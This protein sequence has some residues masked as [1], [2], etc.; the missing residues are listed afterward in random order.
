MHTSKR[1]IRE[2]IRNGTLDR[3][4]GQAML[5]AMDGTSEETPTTEEIPVSKVKRKQRVHWEFWIAALTAVSAVAGL[6]Q[7]CI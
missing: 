3:S 5:E 2:A 1:K 4:V 6:I 7:T